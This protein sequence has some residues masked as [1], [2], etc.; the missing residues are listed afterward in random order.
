MGQGPLSSLKILEFAGIGPGPFCGMLLSDLGADVV[1]IDRPDPR[2]AA[3]GNVTTRGRRS[4]ALDLKTAEGVETCLKL[5][6]AADALIEGFRPGVMERLGLGPEVIHKRNPKLTYGR[7]TGWGQSGPYAHAAGHDI[8]YIA[9]SG[10]L[11]AIGTQE[12][13]IPPLNLVGD[14]GGGALYLAFGLLAGV[15]SARETGRGQVIDCAMSDG[16]ASLMTMFY[17]VHATGTWQAGSREANM[18]DGGAHFYGT[19]RCRDGAW[20]SLGPIEPQFYAL[21]LEKLGLD[22]KSLPDQNDR[23]H[24]PDMRRRFAEAFE[25]KTQA[26]WCDLLAGTDVCFGPVLSMADA[27]NHPHN[28]ARQTFVEVAG[29]LQ[30]APAPRFSETPGAIQRPPVRSGE[31]NAEVLAEWLSRS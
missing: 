3:P 24:W 31:H 22:P 16:A 11:H 20:V 12:K 26:E 10:A 23:T 15:L 27:P 28:A 14:Y 7:M 5:A 4:V 8:N 25:Q 1:R 2:P 30:P 6:E 21:L 13:P 17:G 9:I 19:Y 29:V 18:L